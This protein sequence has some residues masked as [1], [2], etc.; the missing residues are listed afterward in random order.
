[1]D[2]DL[3]DR[4]DATG[5]D[6]EWYEYSKAANPIR[7]S[8]TPPIPFHLFPAALY[9]SGPTRVLPLDLSDQLKCAGPATS[10]GLLASF[11]RIAAGERLVLAPEATS[12]VLY[13]IRGAGRLR[14][15]GET[16]AWAEGDI[17]ALPGGETSFAAE[18]ESAFYI[19]D[20][21]PLL[22]YLGVRVAE[23]RFTPTRYPAARNRAELARVAADPAAA[24]RSRISVLLANARFAGTRTITHTLWAMFGLLPVGATQKPHRHQSVALDY[25]VDCAPGCYSLVGRALAPDG[26][27]ADA[28]RIVWSPG[29]AFVT[30]PGYWHSHHNESG[31][32]AHLIPIQD[33]GLQTHL[34]ALD[35]RFA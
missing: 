12:Q 18:L 2:I 33:A 21:S 7:A 6:A 13:V 35:I 17:L 9:A 22:A 14:C 4:T 27:I 19:V 24:D 15:A 34:R 23:A 10:P 3:L 30:P 31:V 32:P 20:D 5:A 11:A 26:T 1:M 29:I 16:L 8:L 28:E 25:I